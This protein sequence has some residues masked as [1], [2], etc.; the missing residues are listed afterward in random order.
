VYSIAGLSNV[1]NLTGLATT[2]QTLIGNALANVF[3]GGSGIDTVSYAPAPTQGVTVNLQSGGSSGDATNDSFVGIE[4]LTGTDFGD[5]LT[6]NSGTN[7]LDGG[8][9]NDTLNGGAGADILRGGSGA[10]LFKLDGTA[11]TDGQNG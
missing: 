4:N 3:T 11:L 10:D 1:E 9:G 5:N 8:A 7:V 2:G 6:G